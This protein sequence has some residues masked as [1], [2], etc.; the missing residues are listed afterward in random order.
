MGAFLQDLQ[1][2]ISI[3]GSDLR[4]GEETVISINDER[5]YTNLE[6]IELGDVRMGE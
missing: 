5:E 6:L 1:H 2:Q 3:H 4:V